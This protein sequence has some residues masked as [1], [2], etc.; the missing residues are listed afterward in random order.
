[1]KTEWIAAIWQWFLL[2]TSCM[3][4]KVKRC[5]PP[6]KKK[7]ACRL[8]LCR[9]LLI[10]QKKLVSDK[11]LSECHLA[12]TCIQFFLYSFLN[13]IKKYFL[14]NSGQ[15]P[16]FIL[17]KIPAMLGV[18]AFQSTPSL[19]GHEDSENESPSECKRRKHR[20]VGGRYVVW[21]L[22]RLKQFFATLG[23]LTLNK[24]DF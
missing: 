18:D 22:Q 13:N 24:L 16:E 11:C 8:L 12:C 19:R 15:V 7:F 10:M 17:E 14:T 9:H 21:K 3:W 4:T 23:M 6:Q 5:Q 20:S 1:M 2:P